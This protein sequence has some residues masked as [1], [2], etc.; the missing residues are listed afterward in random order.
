MPSVE[1][2]T[3]AATPRHRLELE[4]KDGGGGAGAQGGSGKRASVP[5]RPPILLVARM[6]EEYCWPN[7]TGP[8]RKSTALTRPGPL[9][10]GPMPC[11]CQRPGRAWAAIPARGCLPPPNPNPAAGCRSSRLSVSHPLVLSSIFLSSRP[12][13]FL[14]GSRGLDSPGGDRR[15][16]RGLAWTA[17][18]R[19]HSRGGRQRSRGLGHGG[20]QRAALAT[21]ARGQRLPR[22]RALLSVSLKRGRVAGGRRRAGTGTAGRMARHGTAKLP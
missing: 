14:L 10:R 2:R 3:P 1:A 18:G 21:A 7:G 19:P 22:P 4:V 9:P 5:A 13:L 17:G 16:S 20:Q 12:F 11:P 8:V 15:R 6:R